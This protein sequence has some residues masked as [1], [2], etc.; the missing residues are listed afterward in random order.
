MTS[1]TSND[2]LQH[3]PLVLY[4][5]AVA[6]LSINLFPS[7]RNTLS[8]LFILCALGS[9][10]VTWTYMFKYMYQSYQD[11]KAAAGLLGSYD[12]TRWLEETSLFD[13]AWRYVCRTPERWWIS[14]QLCLFTVGVFTVFLYAEGRASIYVLLLQVRDIL[15]YSLML[16]QAPVILQCEAK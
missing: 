8:K 3:L 12:T 11:H 16:L 13:E 7:P 5:L 10:G 9:L 6:G 14:S 4:L 15:I 1:L 2:I